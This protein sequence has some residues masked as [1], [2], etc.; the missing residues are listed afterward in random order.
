MIILEVMHEVLFL[1]N[2]I[3]I[4]KKKEEKTLHFNINMNRGICE[5]DRIVTLQTF[6]HNEKGEKERGNILSLPM[7][8]LNQF[9]LNL[10]A[11]FHRRSLCCKVIFVIVVILYHLCHI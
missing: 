7:H 10:L 9:S 8:H 11:F 6:C 5:P 3:I 2:G 1:M 4:K